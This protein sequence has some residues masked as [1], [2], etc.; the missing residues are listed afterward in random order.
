VIAP[1]KKV[2]SELRRDHVFS[3]PVRRRSGAVVLLV[4][5]IALGAARRGA[6]GRG[7]R[8]A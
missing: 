5:A 4:L 6:R 7:R 1:G 2:P 3:A 8:S